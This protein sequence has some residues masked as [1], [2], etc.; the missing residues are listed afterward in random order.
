MASTTVRIS[1]EAKEALQKL[2]AHTGKK[3]QEI[4]GEAVESYRRQ[5][6][7]EKANAAFAAL[8]ANPKAWVDEEKE[9]TAWEVTL[10]DGAKD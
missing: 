4:L 7:L 3:M 5:L 6:F 8:R 10:T 9:R 1:L 2:S